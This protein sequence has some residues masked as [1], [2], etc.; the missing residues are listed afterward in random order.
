MK[1][2]ASAIIAVMEAVKAIDKSMTVG[3]GASAYKGVPDQAVKTII[4]EAMRANGLCMLP[5][6]VDAK[7]EV[8]RWEEVSQYGAKQ[9]QS[10]FTEVKTKYLLLHTSGESQVIEGYGHGVDTQDKGA[11]KATTYALKYAL[12]YSF[13]VPTIKIEDADMEHSDEK[14]TPP[15][16][17]NDKPWLNENTDTFLLAVENVTQGKVT[18]PQIEQKYKLSKATKEKLTSLIPK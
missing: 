4:G 3:S 15:Q 9:K 12:L 11:G 13:L 2:L 6:G 17:K 7:T 5:I 18:I 16:P 14:E 10:V 1:N 8:S